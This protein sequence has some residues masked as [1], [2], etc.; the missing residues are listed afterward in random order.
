MRCQASRKL[1]VN[2]FEFSCCMHMKSWQHWNEPQRIMYKRPGMGNTPDPSQDGIKLCTI[3]AG[4]FDFRC[5]CSYIFFRLL[6]VFVYFM[7]L[8]FTHLLGCT[9]SG[10]LHVLCVGLDVLTRCLTDMHLI[11]WVCRTVFSLGCDFYTVICLLYCIVHILC[12]AFWRNKWIII[13]QLSVN[14]FTMGVGVISVPRCSLYHA[15]PV[16]WLMMMQFLTVPN[17]AR[18]SCSLH[19]IAGLS[20]CPVTIPCA[21]LSN[22]CVPKQH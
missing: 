2:H 5:M 20:A 3:S 8:C 6:K 7:I 17:T 21:Y 9:F 22:F 13:I 12:A 11:H 1:L 15:L 19:A 10:T 18:L 16:I 4:L 14:C